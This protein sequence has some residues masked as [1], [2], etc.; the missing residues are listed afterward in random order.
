MLKKAVLGRLSKRKNNAV[1]L[2]S[3]RTGSV[4]ILEVF[5]S[6]VDR[7]LL[8]EDLKLLGKNPRLVSF[9]PNPDKNR[10]YPP[11]TFNPKDI[12]LTGTILTDQLEYFTKLKYDYLISLDDTGNKFVKYILSKTNAQH[13]IGLYHSNFEGLLDMMI[14]PGENGSV[15][16]ELMKYIRMIRK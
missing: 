4:G 6:H 11:N 12:S 1:P 8:I 7:N 10:T 16:R 15:V 13:R 2:D 9:V 14:K 5:E 3:D